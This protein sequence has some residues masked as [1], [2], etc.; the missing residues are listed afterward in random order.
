MLFDQKG[1]F[2]INVEKVWVDEKAEDANVGFLAQLNP[3]NEAK[4]FVLLVVVTL[5]IVNK[6]FR[7]EYTNEIEYEYDFSNLV[8][9]F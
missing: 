4:R 6:D 5:Q 2:L 9:E 3:S 7:F 8:R 1:G